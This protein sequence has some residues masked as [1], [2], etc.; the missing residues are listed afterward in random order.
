MKRVEAIS[1]MVREEG[2]DAVLLTSEVSLIYATGVTAMEGACVVFADGS[3]VFITDGRYIEVAQQRIGAQGITVLCR[4]T[5]QALGNFLAQIF[6]ER[7]VR[8]LFYEDAVLTVAEF[9]RF[10]AQLPDVKDYLPAS[11]KLGVL[12]ACKSEEEIGSVIKAQ[13]IAERA[14]A[15]LL[16]ELYTGITE[17]EAAARLNYYMALDGSE[18]PS[19]DTIMLFGENTSKPHGTPSDRP[20][21]IGDFITMDF[22]AVCEGY[23]SDMTRTVAYG[24]ATDEMREVYETV[25]R[26]QAAAMSVAKAGLRCCG[27][28]S[29]AADVIKAA[30]YGEYFTHALGHTVGLEIHEYPVAGPHCDVVLRDGMIITDEPGIYIAGKFGVRIE[31]MLVI[32]GETPRNLT[33]APKTLTVLPENVLR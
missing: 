7:Q 16:P 28:H 29:A 1:A 4:T 3:A 6:S 19:F 33:E 24:S 21:R 25:L 27:M 20:L 13:R 32:D 14:L 26:A 30:G 11:D 31:D 23:H 8:R 5:A 22:G 10:R 17:R 18:K 2:A 9:A 15:R 12:R